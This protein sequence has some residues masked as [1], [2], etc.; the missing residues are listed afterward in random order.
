MTSKAI[1]VIVFSLALVCALLVLHKTFNISQRLNLASHADVPALK[2]SF[3]NAA[4]LSDLTSA[5]TAYTELQAVLPENDDFLT[6]VAPTYLA[7][8]YIRYALKLSFNQAAH[9]ALIDQAKRLVPNHPYFAAQENI[10]AIETT[11]AKAQAQMQAEEAQ[12]EEEMEYIEQLVTSLP[13]LED[14][15]DLDEPVRKLASHEVYSPPA[16][17]VEV[18]RTVPESAFK[19]VALADEKDILNIPFTNDTC[20]LA[21]YTKSSPLSACIDS[22]AHNRYGPALFVVGD[23]RDAPTLAF[24]QQ[25][26]S[27]D[28]YERFCDQTG[29]CYDDVTEA[30]FVADGGISL[31]LSDVEQTVRDYNVYCQMTRDCPVIQSPHAN[32]PISKGQLQRYALWLT[33]QTGYKYRLLSEQDTL[34]VYDYFERCVASQTCPSSI[35]SQLGQVFSQKSRLLVRELDE[36]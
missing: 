36:G 24:T 14:E 3:F 16:I 5:K 30:P 4:Q 31:D 17:P 2:A 10:V 11:L 29:A 6:S 20:A 15:I 23:R 22:I 8:L 27:R 19:E 32:E 28:D 7:D 1:R 25:P 13:A 21:Y 12:F 26:V 34:L 35:L 9:D 33:A 18:E